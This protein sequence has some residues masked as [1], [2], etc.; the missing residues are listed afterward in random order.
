MS[1]EIRPIF[2]KEAEAQL[3]VIQTS[4]NAIYED[5]QTLDKIQLNF[6]TFK[7]YK[8][9]VEKQAKET[10]KLTAE[11]KKLQK[12]T[13]NL[14]FAQSE[15]GK[16]LARIREQTKAVNKEN[17]EAAKD[18]TTAAT[19]YDRL[20]LSLTQA[21]KEYRDLAATQGLASKET[22][23][24]QKRVQDL[25][26]EV[27][28]I[29]EP[30]KRFGDNVGNYAS[31]VPGFDKLNGVLSGIGVNL[32][33]IA[34]NG[35]GATKTFAQIRGGIVK[36]TQAA[37]RFIATPIGIAIVALAG[38]GIASKEF[39]KFN[40]QV[41]KTNLIVEQLANT[42]GK[43]TDKLREQA[44]AIEKAYG[45][46]FN[47]AV[48]ELTDLQKDFG[49][50]SEEAFDIY[51]DGLARGGAQS[52]EF[53]DS[54]REYG[55]LFAD[56][57][58]T[59]QEFLDI[60][61]TGIDL[62]IYNDKLPDAIKEA[63]LSLKEQTTATR[64]ALTNAFGA[65]FTNDIL[66]QV[67]T[68][69]KS[70]K[71]ALF[72]I[73]AAAEDAQ[74]NQQQLAQLTAD[75]FR[76]AGEDAG[77]AQM[78]FEAL[79][80]SIEKQTESLGKYGE[81]VKK[82]A[83]L[84]NDLEEA[85]TRALKSDAAI[86]FTQRL[87][88]L[89]TELETRFFDSIAKIREGIE[90]TILSFR[91]FYGDIKIL[92][93]QIPKI[94]KAALGDVVRIFQETTSKILQ[95][96]NVIK[97]A[98]SG[99]IQ[100]AL[101]TFSSIGKFNFEL[102]NTNKLLAE[103]AQLRAD[104][105]KETVMQYNE[106]KELLL[107]Q[108]KL[109]KEMKA[110]A[111][112]STAQ[113]G[114]RNPYD[115]S[116]LIRKAESANEQALIEAQEKLTDQ[117]K[118]GV[119][120][121]EEYVNGLADLQKEYN[122]KLIQDTIEALEK[123]LATE[124]LTAE[125]RKEVMEELADFRIEMQKL[126]IDAVE[127]QAKKEIE[128]LKQQLAEEK[129]LR[130]GARKDR[131]KSE[132][133]ARAAREQSAEEEEER[134]K[135]IKEAIREAGFDVLTGLTNN[136]F[137]AQDERENIEL[138][139]FQEAQ[140]KRAAYVDELLNNGVITAEE[141]SARKIRLEQETARKEAEIKRKQAVRDKNQA[142]FNIAIDT[143]RGIVA[144]LASLNP[145]LATA[146]GIAGAAQAI[147]VATKPIPQY[148]KGTDSSEEGLAWVG[149]RGPELIEYPDGTQLMAMTE[150]LTYLPKGSKVHNNEK[151]MK[152]QN[153]KELVGEIKGLRRDL[154]KKKMSVGINVHNNSRLDYIYG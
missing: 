77:G 16:E 120:S 20:R 55:S 90:N 18:A 140:D 40:I 74:L 53:G 28:A 135:T 25:R 116:D 99:N 66:N 84:F 29:N 38:I 13:E 65:S 127:E 137:D 54:I 37:A 58:F 60:L 59:A 150:S 30:I 72:A 109:E 73:S 153:N 81:A 95:Y 71:E 34:E 8:V 105:F 64:D 103:T 33:E 6:K 152:M 39:F 62:G 10:E 121:A 113:G 31:A 50:T 44:T 151:T 91:I 133:E 56:A 138:Q 48:K 154:S 111:Q 145:A 26:E 82:S 80:T 108:A 24:A 43:A 68:G 124:Q 76:G 69:E 125:E 75:V 14:A 35:T 126:A 118:Q 117:Y 94:A 4:I 41:A 115:V 12:A 98:A 112:K 32:N 22:I 89:A 92:F 7:E 78:I 102:T 19:G 104:N 42:T 110:N 21:E 1:G 23:E 149:E 3:K 139:K 63:G 9:A 17:R 46:E 134:I 83:D 96:A 67:S 45:K 101:G 85:K 79:N 123:V 5:A 100:G 122:A 143:A 61:N 106:E 148:Y 2:S 15:E 147:V 57:G 136:F 132:E 70:V 87:K 47:D 119:I 114:E 88:N 128:I 93:V 36:A 129:K 107:E 52:A 130:E 97:Q 86:A 131:E 141:A 27:D 144:A 51:N 146:I 11:Q 49:I 142:L